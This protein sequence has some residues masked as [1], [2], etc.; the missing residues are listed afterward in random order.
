MGSYPTRAT[1]NTGLTAI[2]IESEELAPLLTEFK[3]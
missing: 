3:S 2:V 1:A